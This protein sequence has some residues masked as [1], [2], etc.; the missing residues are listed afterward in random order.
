MSKVEGRLVWLVLGALPLVCGPVRANA[1]GDGAPVPSSPALAAGSIF[2]AFVPTA[3]GARTWAESEL[4]KIRLGISFDPRDELDRESSYVLLALHAGTSKDLALEATEG[5]RQDEEEEPEAI[6][7]A[8]IVELPKA[9]LAGTRTE[10]AFAAMGLS[11]ADLVEGPEVPGL[12]ITL[13]EAFFSLYDWGLQQAINLRTFVHGP[14]GPRSRLRGDPRTA[15]DLGSGE[16]YFER[17]GSEFDTPEEKWIVF[18]KRVLRSA[19]KIL[20]GLTIGVL[21][22][23]FVRNTV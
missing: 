9:M 5:P 16:R 2:Y 14:T 23:G 13:A 18:T 17:P 1:T 3:F 20:L 11:P 8:I 6:E 10:G 12:A 7:D 4:E 22:W 15:Y 21:I 19:C